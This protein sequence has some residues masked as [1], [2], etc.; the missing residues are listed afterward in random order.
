MST[1]N[2]DNLRRSKEDKLL[3]GTMLILKD[4][5]EKHDIINKLIY[6][7]E[8]LKTAP[9]SNE[10]VLKTITMCK[11]YL[12]RSHDIVQKSLPKVNSEVKEIAEVMRRMEKQS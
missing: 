8:C 11:D 2:T 7:T 4:N 1:H 9:L 3:E 6:Y 12:Q 10:D 5:K